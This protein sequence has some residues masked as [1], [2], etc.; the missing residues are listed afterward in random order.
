VK[1]PSA[2][3]TLR[4]SVL[5]R[6]IEASRPRGHRRTT[7]VRELRRSVARDLE[8]LLNSRVLVPDHWHE[9]AEARTSVLTYGVPDF[10]TASWTST[11]DRTALANAI[12]SAIQRFEPRLSR[13]SVRVYVLSLPEPA[14]FRL[15]YRIS[16]MLHV[17]P[18]REPVVY[19]TDLDLERGALQVREVG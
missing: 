6:L 13:N 1:Q 18:I 4:P 2:A 7:S 19:D 15:R 8:W 5:D 17:E 11:E 16:A 12:E 10:A 9:L 3:N 14:D